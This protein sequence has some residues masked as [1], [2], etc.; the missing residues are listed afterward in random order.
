[1]GSEVSGTQVDGSARSE[2]GRWAQLLR[3]HRPAVPAGDDDG[4]N[5]AADR[6]EETAPATP[7]PS[8]P[9]NEPRA[10]Q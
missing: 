7:G 5:A 9:A 6:A 8:G 10:P 4:P 1:P 3:R 2:R